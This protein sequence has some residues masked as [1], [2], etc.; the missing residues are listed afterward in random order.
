M[1][2]VT[3]D[4]FAS[5]LHPHAPKHNRKTRKAM[6]SRVVTLRQCDQWSSISSTRRRPTNGLRESVAIFSPRG[7][8][9]GGHSSAQLKVAG[10][11]LQALVFP[12]A[13]NNSRLPAVVRRAGGAWH[14]QRRHSAC[15]S[16]QFTADWGM[17]SCLHTWHRPP[18]ISLPR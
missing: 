15:Q 2:Q 8:N 7:I 17:T 10:H 18:L 5:G 11:C 1:H 6:G 3:Y 14:D 9:G 12:S 16:Y 4:L 13:P